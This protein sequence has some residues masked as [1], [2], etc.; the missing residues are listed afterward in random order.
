MAFFFFSSFFFWQ[1][2]SQL[3]EEPDEPELWPEELS[4]D[5]LLP[6]E[7]DSPEEPPLEELPEELLPVESHPML[8]SQANARGL[9]NN[10]T[11]ASRTTVAASIL[12]I[13][14]AT[15][16]DS[17]HTYWSTRWTDTV[18]TMLSIGN[19]RNRGRVAI[20]TARL[21]QRWGGVGQA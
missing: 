17:R 4:P 13:V 15:P 16:E 3:L 10:V 1:A 14:I 20:N 11:E 6:D 21:P 18:R 5:E 12:A 19:G 2:E 8:G 9:P 7:L